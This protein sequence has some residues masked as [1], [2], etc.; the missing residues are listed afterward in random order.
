MVFRT[1]TAATL[2]MSSSSDDEIMSEM[3]AKTKPRLLGAAFLA[4]GLA[5]PLMAQTPVPAPVTL[6]QTIT[7]PGVDGRLDHMSVDV[8]GRRLFASGLANGTV[9]VIDL[10]T[11]KRLRTITGVKEP[12][13]IVYVPDLNQIFVADGEGGAV[14]AFDGQS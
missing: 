12:E 8:K 5:L 1:P 10:T 4:C 11:A 3:Y 7:L 6:V 9:E 14:H 2:P 13:G